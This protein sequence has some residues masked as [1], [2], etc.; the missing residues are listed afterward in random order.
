M[1]PVWDQDAERAA[2]GAA[3]VNVPAAAAVAGG[4]SEADLSRDGER[5]I[6]RAIRRLHEGGQPIDPLTIAADLDRAGE[7]EKAGGR[8]A[9]GALAASCP[10]P[11]NAGA[12]IERV[13]ECTRTREQEAPRAADL[14]AD[15]EA[16]I[17]RFVV[18][19]GDAAAAALALFVGHTYALDGA[20]A[21]PYLLIVSPEKRSGKTRLLGILELIVAQP[22]SVVGASEPAIFRKIDHDRPTLMLDE[23]DAVFGSAGERTEPIRALLNGGNRPGAAIS[24]CVGDGGSMRVQDFKVFCP[25][26]LAGIDTGHRIPDTIRDRAIPIA[27]VRK[28]QAEPVERFR[29]RDAEAQTEPLREALTDWSEVVTDRLRD[30]RPEIP[31][32]LDDRAAE[33]WEPLLAI[34]D[35][36]GGEWPQRARQAAETLSGSAGAE[37]LA[38]GTMVLGA[39]R[40]AFAGADRI[41]SAALCEAINSEEELPFGGWRDGKGLDGRRLAQLLRPY[42]VRPRT[43]RLDDDTTPKG[44]LRGQFLDAWDRWLPP[45]DN[46]PQAPHPP[47]G[48]EAATEKPHGQADVADVADVAAISRGV[49]DV[50]GNGHREPH[51]ATI[52][53]EAG[54]PRL[55]EGIEAA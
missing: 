47:Q 53:D 40:D 35:L 33:A 1:A 6:L 10:A 14:L 16:T 31:T 42:G 29:H 52:V 20:H 50:A 45:L 25:K 2:L 17:R 26:V 46:P 30:A 8:D 34:A 12:Y 7:L 18:L 9:I 27:M 44:Y 21:T 49:A 24:R 19:P 55:I 51:Q 38:I 5:L 13:R 39:V 11:G 28:T 22:W 3:L 15:V 41:G 54:I 37:E 4:L 48:T 43:V 23:I 36:A 32:A